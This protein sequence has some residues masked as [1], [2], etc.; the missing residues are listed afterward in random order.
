MLDEF[1]SSG[2]DRDEEADVERPAREVERIGADTSGVDPVPFRDDDTVWSVI[3]EEI[4][5]G[6]RFRGDGPGARSV[7][8]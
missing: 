3:G 7:H 6:R 4:A 8:G 1:T 2:D 5:M